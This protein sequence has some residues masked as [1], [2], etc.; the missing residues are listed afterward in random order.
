MGFSIYGIC[1]AKIAALCKK[2]Q[3]TYSSRN[4]S[5]KKGHDLS[6]FKSRASNMESSKGGH[7]K[8]IRVSLNGTCSIY[9]NIAS[10]CR[11]LHVTLTP[12][13]LNYM[14]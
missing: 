4:F 3:P 6:L 9:L 7:D 12:L 8:Y 14:S 2:A 13:T 11:T 5:L 1:I 10:I